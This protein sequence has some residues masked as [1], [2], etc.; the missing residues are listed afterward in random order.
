MG[1]DTLMRRAIFLDR[2]GVLNRAYERGGITY[3]PA[4]VRE[5]ELL[6]GVVEALQMLATH[7]VLLVVVTNQPDVARGTQQRQTVEAINAYLAERLP[8]HDVFTCYHDT[9]DNCGCRKPK[10]G[11][12][13]QAAQEYDIDLSQSFLIGDRWSDIVAGQVVGCRTFLVTTLYSQRERCAPDYEVA[14][15]LEAAHTIL[16]LLGT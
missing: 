2:D 14:D 3:P 5:V 8:L 11:L 7:D 15:V 6:P 9:A 10:P 4:S 1:V 13:L 12:L 16:S